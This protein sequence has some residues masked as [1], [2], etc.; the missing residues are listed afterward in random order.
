MNCFM[1]IFFCFACF[2]QQTPEN[3]RSRIIQKFEQKQKSEGYHFLW[4]SVSAPDKFHGYMLHYYGFKRLSQDEARK[5]LVSNLEEILSMINTEKNLIPT[6]YRYPLKPEDINLM[7][8]YFE[9]EDEIAKKPYVTTVSSN[10]DK[11]NYHFRINDN[12]EDDEVVTESYNEAYEKV[13]GHPRDP[14]CEPKK[15]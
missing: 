7:Y 3:L 14:Q 8:L 13:Y 11:V 1:K 2:F 5:E 4:R 6:L 9:G 15:R 12:I 10:W